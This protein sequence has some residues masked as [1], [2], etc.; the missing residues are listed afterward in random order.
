MV[1]ITVLTIITPLTIIAIIIIMVVVVAV[2][3]IIQIKVNISADGLCKRYICIYVCICVYMYV[4]VCICVCCMPLSLSLVA[5][6]IYLSKDAC[7]CIYGSTDVKMDLRT[8]LCFFAYA[9]MC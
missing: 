1:I 8:Y 6:S 7:T 5:R 3:I 2:I 9:S 4:Y